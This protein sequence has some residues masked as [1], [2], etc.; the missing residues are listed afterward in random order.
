MKRLI[1]ALALGVF[2]L[3]VAAPLVI[4]GNAVAQSTKGTGAG[5]TQPIANNYSRGRVLAQ[6][7]PC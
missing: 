4:A 6:S 7:L 5:C 3:T 1:A 2:V